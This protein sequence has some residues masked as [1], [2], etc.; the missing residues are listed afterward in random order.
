MRT[1]NSNRSPNFLLPSFPKV[2]SL[3]TWAARCSRLVTGVATIAL[4]CSL[5]ACTAQNEDYVG[6]AVDCI[7]S[8]GEDPADHDIVILIDRHPNGEVT[9]YFGSTYFKTSDAFIVMSEIEDVEVDDGLQFESDAEIGEARVAI[10]VELEE[11]G[12]DE[13]EGELTYQINGTDVT[14]EVE[15]EL[16]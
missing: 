14:C 13:L 2:P 16:E 6:E 10:E 8:T 15:V 3:S 11:A 1:A 4:G 9:G 5:A 12:K 7:A